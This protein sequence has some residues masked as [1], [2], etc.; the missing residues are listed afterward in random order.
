M[1]MNT[2]YSMLKNPLYG[3]RYYALRQEA[4]E[5]AKRLKPGKTSGKTSHAK[6]PPE[7]WHRLD[8]PIVSPIVSWPEWEAV[9]ARLVINKL[10]SSRN[11]RRVYLL[12]GMLCCAHDGRRLSGRGGAKR[13]DYYYVC[14]KRYRSDMGAPE[15]ALPQL[16]GATIERQV[17][18]SVAHFLQDP[19]AFMAEVERRRAGRGSHSELE[20]RIALLRKKINHVDSLETEL[21]GMK[22][23]GQASDVAFERQS[24]LLR[25]ERV[26]CQDEL[27]RHN[28]TQVAMRETETAF[29]A[30]ATMRDSIIARLDSATLEDRRWMLQCLNTRVEVDGESVQ[31]SVGVPSQI[32]NS[33]QYSQVQS[34]HTVTLTGSDS[35]IGVPP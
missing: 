9:Q 10:E 1:G 19:R 22:L 23:R 27:E 34:N 15:C 12:A 31:I 33:V 32:Q 11:A 2:I 8:F 28:Q 5:P 7:H 14:T 24:A 35:G 20:E 6:L 25:A 16:S 3:G 30:L 17:W 26:H 4:R 21:V 18:D 13:Q 29:E